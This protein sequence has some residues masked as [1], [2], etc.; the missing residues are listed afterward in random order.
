MH[1]IGQGATGDVIVAEKANVSVASSLF[2]NNR[3]TVIQSDA[4]P[5]QISSSKFT[6]G[7]GTSYISVKDS[8]INVDS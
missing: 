2:Y 1:S 7:L 3:N 5:V 6:G 4:S 8:S